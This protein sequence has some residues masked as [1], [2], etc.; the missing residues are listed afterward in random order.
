MKRIF[1][2]FLIFILT[3]IIAQE[4]IWAA[5]YVTLTTGKTYTFTGVVQWH[6]AYNNNYS[7]DNPTQAWLILD[8]T[9]KCRVD[10]STITENVKDIFVTCN[11]GWEKYIGKRVSLTGSFY[12]TDWALCQFSEKITVLNDVKPTKVTL[13]KAS[14]TLNVGKT[15]TLK[16]TVSPGNATNK[17]VTWTSSNKKVATVSSSGKVKG[18][19]K[20]TATITVKT[21]N[22][23]TAKCK[24]TVK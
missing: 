13:S 1:I 7:D 21:A 16:A 8:E 19:K 20:G 17:N 2:L 14:L 6:D 5:S 3:L 9:L 12:C 15:H 11:D 4:T 23:K 18:I 24:V 22:G 10:G